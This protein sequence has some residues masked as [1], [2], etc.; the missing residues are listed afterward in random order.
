MGISWGAVFEIKS[1]SKWG[2]PNKAPTENGV[3]ENK[4]PKENIETPPPPK[5][6]P[7]REIRLK[8]M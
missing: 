1:E 2:S 5:K 4:I 7:R 3:V 8:K 6:R